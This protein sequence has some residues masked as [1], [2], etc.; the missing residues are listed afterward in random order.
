MNVCRR[1]VNME[2]AEANFNLMISFEDET[3]GKHRLLWYVKKKIL[4]YMGSS[5]EA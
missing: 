4:K 2:A 3:M 5:N 1:Q